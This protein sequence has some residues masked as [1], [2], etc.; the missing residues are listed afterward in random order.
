MWG[1]KRK[2]DTQGAGKAPDAGT[3]FDLVESLTQAA[4]SSGFT[5]AVY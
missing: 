2:E 3:E 1:W 4:A 5:K